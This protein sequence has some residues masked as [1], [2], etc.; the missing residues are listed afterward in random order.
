MHE[1]ALLKKIC[2]LTVTW[3]YCMKK[4]R[5]GEHTALADAARACRCFFALGIVIGLYFG[6]T[7]TAHY[8]NEKEVN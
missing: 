8:T 2:C 4:K 3:G 6:E 1:F 7:K 5:R